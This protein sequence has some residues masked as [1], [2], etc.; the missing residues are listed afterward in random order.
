MVQW[1]CNKFHI[2]ELNTIQPHSSAGEAVLVA[3]VSQYKGG[4]DIWVLGEAA[5]NF[6]SDNGRHFHKPT[7]EPHSPE[8]LLQK[9]S[10]AVQRGNTATVLVKPFTSMTLQLS[11]TLRNIWWVIVGI[12]NRNQ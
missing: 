12:I 1:L 3:R 4:E 6:R 9:M 10:V 11:S 7:G 5:V 2:P 8:F